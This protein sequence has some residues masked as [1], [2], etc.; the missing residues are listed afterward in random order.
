M[1]Q[2]NVLLELSKYPNLFTCI[3]FLWNRKSYIML[4]NIIRICWKLFYLLTRSAITTMGHIKI[5]WIWAAFQ[6]ITGL[7]YITSVR[8]KCWLRKGNAFLKEHLTG[9]DLLPLNHSIFLSNK[10]HWTINHLYIKDL[11]NLLFR[12]IFA[13]LIDIIHSKNWSD[14]KVLFKTTAKKGI[15]PCSKSD[16]KCWSL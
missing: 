4:L 15:T 3:M 1:I 13:V 12:T 7:H 10:R 9:T 14:L 5:V 16:I 6:W 8:H 2:I 11:G